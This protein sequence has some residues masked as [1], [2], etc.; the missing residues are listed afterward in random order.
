LSVEAVSEARPL[1]GHSRP[2]VPSGARLLEE[3][4]PTRAVVLTTMI[5]NRRFCIDC[6]VTR[7]SMRPDEVEALLVTIGG[8]L[9]VHRSASE[10]CRGC[11]EIAPTISVDGP[12]D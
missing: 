6:I 2:G 9:R 7:T 4:M 3:F 8:A 10:P 12:L 5:L 1:R 11:G